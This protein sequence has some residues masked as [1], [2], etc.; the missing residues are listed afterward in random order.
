MGN[1][2][3]IKKSKQSQN[4]KVKKEEKLEQ[5]NVIMVGLDGSGKTTLLQHLSSSTNGVISEKEVISGFIIEHLNYKNL[6][7][8]AWNIGMS[9]NKLRTEWDALINVIYQDIDGIIFVIDS[10]DRIRIDNEEGFFWDTACRHFDILLDKEYVQ[11]AAILVICTKQDMIDNNTDTM[12]VNTISKKLELNTLRNRQWYIQSC[13]NDKQ[14]TITA[15]E[16]LLDTLNHNKY[17]YKSELKSIILVS[18]FIHE[19]DKKYKLMSHIPIEIVKFI[20]LLYKN[21]D[22]D[23]DE[24]TYYGGYN[25]TSLSMI[26]TMTTP[27]L[28]MQFINRKDDDPDYIEDDE[29]FID[30]LN[31]EAL[32]CDGN[33]KWNHYNFMRM[34]WILFKLYDR[35]NGLKLIWKYTP[36]NVTRTYFWSQLIYFGMNRDENEIENNL[37]KR[38]F[39]YFLIANPSFSNDYDILMNKYYSQKLLNKMNEKENKNEMILPDLINL[40]SIITNIKKVKVKIKLNQNYKRFNDTDYDFLNHFENKTFK[41]W[42]GHISFLRVIYCYI[43]KLK[44]QYTSIIQ[45]KWKQFDSYNYNMTIT[46]FWIHI[47]RYYINLYQSQGDIKHEEKSPQQ[48]K[49]DNADKSFE[50]F[51]NFCASKYK[52]R[53]EYD[54]WWKEYYSEKLM[55]NT[56]S[57]KLVMPDLKQLPDLSS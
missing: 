6:S 41:T 33:S 52:C 51:L 10:T 28:L 40:P 50:G 11:N 21:P 32:R 35:R 45:S 25:D 26:D 38:D 3:S 16:W 29:K 2:N 12:S 20:H 44:A 34:I 15:F 31:N 27:I 1:R 30:S 24:Y 14:E 7:I 5:K 42:E 13:S 4:I 53:I 55:K 17:C 23:Y 19:M 56:P 57:N 18:G 46:Y 39:N 49:N 48:M 22:Y 8:N 54:E 36:Y 43:Q 9:D 37:K 47:M